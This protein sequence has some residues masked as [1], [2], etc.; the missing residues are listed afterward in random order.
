MADILSTL[1]ARYARE[2]R[3]FKQENAD[4]TDEYKRITDQVGRHSCTL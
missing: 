3:R 2:E 1:K 4:L